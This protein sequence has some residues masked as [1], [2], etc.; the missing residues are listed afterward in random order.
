MMTSEEVE[1]SF[2]SSLQVELA[3]QRERWGVKSPE[4]GSAVPVEA[5]THGERAYAELDDRWRVETVT[6]SPASP[7]KP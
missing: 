1:K 2:K 7:L 5:P 4:E 3:K 6:A